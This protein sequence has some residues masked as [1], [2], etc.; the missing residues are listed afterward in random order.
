MRVN[1]NPIKMKKNLIVR[2]FLLLLMTFTFLNF[3]QKE[4]KPSPF[5]SSLKIN[6]FV[7]IDQSPIEENNDNGLI[8]SAR[9]IKVIKKIVYSDKLF[10]QIFSLAALYPKF[11]YQNFSEKLCNGITS[12]LYRFHLF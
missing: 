5:A 1:I 12:Q 8:T 10:L 9:S 3:S 6:D 4:I 11:V 7:S 2:L